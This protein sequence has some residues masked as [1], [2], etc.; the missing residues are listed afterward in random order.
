MEYKMQG[1]GDWFRVKSRFACSEQDLYQH[2][3]FLAAG[4]VNAGEHNFYVKVRVLGRPDMT[5][6]HVF[7]ELH[8]TLKDVLVTRD[9][10]YAEY[11][12]HAWRIYSRD[13]TVVDEIT[14]YNFRKFFKRM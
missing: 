7:V 12:C 2:L 8:G 14:M 1:F 6:Y 3:Y 11:A 9:E 13:I 5:R 4:M 10:S